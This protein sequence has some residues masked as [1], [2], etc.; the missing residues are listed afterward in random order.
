[1]NCPFMSIFLSVWP[2]KLSFRAKRRSYILTLS[3]S[4]W[5]EQT[6][7]MSWIWMSSF[8]QSRTSK[9]N[10]SRVLLRLFR[11]IIF[12]LINWN[13]TTNNKA[14]RNGAIWLQIPEVLTIHYPANRLPSGVKGEKNSANRA[15]PRKIRRAWSGGHSPP[16][17]HPLPVHARP[18]PLAVFFFA[19]YPTS[20]L[21]ELTIHLK[22]DPKKADGNQ[23][24]RKLSGNY[25][26]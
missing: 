24:V 16:R 6:W 13:H 5:I 18:V 19:L 26:L 11:G 25:F 1:M 12:F 9:Y 4:G 2:Q 23:M 22:K 21:S 15:K 7:N 14:K 20:E 17:A 8:N 10:S 3:R